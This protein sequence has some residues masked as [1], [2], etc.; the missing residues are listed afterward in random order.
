LKGV[1]DMERLVGME[2][3]IDL[4]ND[5]KVCDDW[6]TKNWGLLPAEL[7][8]IISRG[9]CRTEDYILYEERKLKDDKR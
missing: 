2:R 4:K 7:Q 6:T 8:K 9:I 5:L 3:L 1:V